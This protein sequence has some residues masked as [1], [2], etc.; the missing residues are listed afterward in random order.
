MDQAEFQQKQGEVYADLAAA[1]LVSIPD[2]WDAVVL[3]LGAST[4]EHGME[5]MSHE[6]ANP[7]L[8]E[9]LVT[10]MPDVSVYSHPRRLEMLFREFGA[11]WKKTVPLPIMHLLLA[12]EQ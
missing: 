7:K 9:G 11:R 10:V 4:L 8:T 2:Y 3:T 6:L 1:V 12:A 5:S